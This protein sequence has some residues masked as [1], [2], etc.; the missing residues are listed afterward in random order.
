VGAVSSDSG[1]SWQQVGQAVTL[2]AMTTVNV[3]LV[4]TAHKP[5]TSAAKATFES[6]D[7]TKAQ[8]W[9]GSTD[10]HLFADASIGNQ[11]T[12]GRTEAKTADTLTAKMGDIGTNNGVNADIFQYGFKTF[13]GDGVAIT[14]VT[15]QTAA[16]GAID[17]YAKAG[18]MVRETAADT[19]ANVFLGKTPSGATIQQRTTTGGATTPTNVTAV[20]LPRWFKLLRTGNTFIGS[21]STDGT[22][23]L[24]VGDPAVFTTFNA[25]PLV[26]LAAS[27]HSTA[28][29]ITAIFESGV[30]P[31]PPGL[32]WTSGLT[33]LTWLDAS[34]G[35]TAGS[36]TTA[37]TEET[38]IGSGADI[39]GNAD[40]FFY[41]WKN[42]TGNATLTARVTVLGAYPNG[43]INSYA[44]AGVMFRDSAT[45]GSPNA[46]MT[47]TAGQGASFQSR[48]VPGA[49]TPTPPFVAAPIGYWV[50]V[51]RSGASNNTYTGWVS[52]NGTSWGTPVGTVT[53]STIAQTALVGLAVTSHDATKS[54]Q[55]KFTNVT[56]TQP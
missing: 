13:S 21:M 31:E 4:A 47:L 28:N 39:Y 53:M 37:G 3:G 34:M 19:S 24:Q 36:H 23:W 38:I 27:S 51:Q 2:P 22:N 50:R 48:T 29:T 16:P 14:K 26:G 49:G 7:W 52:S 11:S 6:F 54:V 45:P 43:T 41:S 9:S 55:A 42:I 10:P 18:L 35:L 5:S 15:S 44:K 32:Q 40:A 56:Y 1:T 20:G 33:G 46:F 17:A 25:N 30:T 12:G 8:G